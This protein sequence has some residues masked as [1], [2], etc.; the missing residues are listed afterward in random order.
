LET[1]DKSWEDAAKQVVATAGKTLKDLRIAE[2]VSQDMKI[3][4]GRL[5]HYRTKVRLSFNLKRSNPEII[6]RGQ[7]HLQPCLSYIIS[8]AYRERIT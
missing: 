4:M 5:W 1:S 7:G 8:N 6:F 3:E 2:I